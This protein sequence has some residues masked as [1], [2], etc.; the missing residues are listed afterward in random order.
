M[1]KPRGFAAPLGACLGDLLSPTLAARGLGEASLVTH[2]P[3]IVG[4]AI[5]AYARPI[6]LQWPPRGSKRDPDQAGAPAILVLRIRRRLRAGS[7]A[8]GRD[9]RRA[10]QRA[11]GLALRGAARL[12]ARPAAAA[13]KAPHAPAASERPGDDDGARIRGRHRGRRLARG[14]GEARRACHRRGG[15]V[16]RHCERSEAIHLSTS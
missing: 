13:R 11:S 1:S 2:W 10:S 16:D 15:E 8:R 9:H 5:A 14:A 12:S 3:E 6:Q 4:A 7:A